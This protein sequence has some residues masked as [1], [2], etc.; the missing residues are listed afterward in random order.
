MEILN[1]YSE[2]NNAVGIFIF[3]G[4]AGALILAGCCI[5][6]LIC[7]E[8]K[9]LF[10]YFIGLIV[11]AAITFGLIKWIPV[12]ETKYIQVKI[13]DMNKLDLDKYEI[14]NK[15]GKIITLKMLE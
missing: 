3:F 11:V 13:I 4:V 15:Q 5:Y 7:R 1:S 8:W 9:K 10:S 12:T 14:V 6:Q 2:Y